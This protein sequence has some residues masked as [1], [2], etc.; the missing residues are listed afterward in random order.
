MRIERVL[1][2]HLRLPLLFPF[3]TSFGRVN[4]K[5]T[6]IVRVDAEGLA[7]WGECPV[8]ATP[9]YSYET[10]ATAQHALRDFLVPLLLRGPYADPAELPERFAPVRGHPMAKAG[11]EAACWDLEARRRGVPLA[12]VYGGEPRRIPTG[13]SLGIEPTVP[14]LVERAR[15]ALATGYRRIKIKI[16]P[17]WDEAPL[18][19]LRAEFPKAAFMADANGAY[20]PEDAARLARLDGFGLTMLEQPLHFEDFGEHA[21]LARKLVTPICLDESI[22]NPGDAAHAIAIGACRII[23]IKP[24]RVGGPTQARRV[25]DVCRERGVPAWCGGLLETGIGRA[26]NLAIATLPGFSMPGDLSA[27]DRYWAEDLIEP[28]VRLEPDGTIAV[29]DRVGLGYDVVPGRLERHAVARW[30][31][32]GGTGA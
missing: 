17:G 12:R 3:E 4:D 13:I 9:G 19:A 22:R 1:G 29:P 18:A 23:N 10:V 8:A 20:R 6:V 25:H 30:T 27:S 26:H 5:E 14:E 21:A 31:I 2:W 15:R 32:D 16:K 11:L 7:G 24:A 28:P